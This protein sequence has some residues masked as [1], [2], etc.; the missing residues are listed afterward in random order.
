MDSH[1]HL[2]CLENEIIIKG[3]TSGSYLVKD[4]D[5]KKKYIVRIEGM[6]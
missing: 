3:L 2:V 6:Y 1:T 5:D 4:Y